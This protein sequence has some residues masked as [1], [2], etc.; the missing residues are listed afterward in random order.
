MQCSLTNRNLPY[1]LTCNRN[2]ELSYMYCTFSL[3]EDYLTIF[4]TVTYCVCL[5]HT[6]ICMYGA[7]WYLEWTLDASSELMQSVVHVATVT[8]SKLKAGWRCGRGTEGLRECEPSRWGCLIGRSLQS[9]MHGKR[10]LYFQ[11]AITILL[12]SVVMEHQQKMSFVVGDL[13]D[14]AVTHETV[15][16]NLVFFCLLCLSKESW[17]V[18]LLFLLNIVACLWGG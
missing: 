14:R 12:R 16:L 10:R 4:Y 5:F 7:F 3:I 8:L 6:Y 17:V 1:T 18:Y 2:R 13:C 11:L 9:W 15:D